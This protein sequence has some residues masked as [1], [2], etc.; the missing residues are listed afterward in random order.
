[1]KQSPD[2]HSVRGFTL[3]ELLITLAVAGI[4][5][6][7]AVPSFKETLQQSRQDSRVMDLTGALTF[8]RS[9]AIK[10]SSRVSVCA[11][12]SDTSCG[13]NWNQGWIVFVDNA[14]T[15]GIIDAS[16]TVLKVASPLPTGFTLA[17][18]AITQGVADATQRSYVRFGP[19]GLSNWRGSGTFTFCDDRGSRA[20]RAVNVSMSGDVRQARSTGDGTLYDTF[21]QAITCDDS[22]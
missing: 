15:A 4:L 18:S 5:L 10:Q 8:A 9:E 20:A 22:P 19:R 12:N 2:S 1:M 3:M 11:R 16:E 6:G 17:N 13:T 14:A 7:I 21:G